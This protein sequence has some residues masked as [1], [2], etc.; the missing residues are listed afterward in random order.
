M[1]LISLSGP[2][3]LSTPEPS[4][5]ARLLPAGRFARQAVSGSYSR[6]TEGKGPGKQT[7]EGGSYTKDSVYRQ[8]Y[9]QPGPDS[10][11]TKPNFLSV[12]ANESL[13][14]ALG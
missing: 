12:G 2:G 14:F 4:E 9:R 13:S 5:G 7:W 10:G 6:P 8:M 1:Q 3:V 11:E